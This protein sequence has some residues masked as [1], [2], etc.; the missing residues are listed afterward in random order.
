MEKATQYIFMNMSLNHDFYDS[1]IFSGKINF[2]EPSLQQSVQDV[3]KRI[4]MHNEFL[5]ITD[6]MMDQQLDD[7]APE[8]A[9]RYYEWMD[10]NKVRLKKEIPKITNKLQLYFKISHSMEV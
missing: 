3:F 8:K 5:I 7:S 2:L 6:R 9:Y 1:L 10:K 4:K